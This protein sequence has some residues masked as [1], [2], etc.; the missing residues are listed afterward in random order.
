MTGHQPPE[1][2]TYHNRRVGD[3]DMHEGLMETEKSHAMARKEVLA[4]LICSCFC[5]VI[6]VFGALV[7][8]GAIGGSED[9]GLILMPGGG[10]VLFC[11]SVK[12]VWLKWGKKGTERNRMGS[13]TTSGE[14]FPEFIRRLHRFNSHIQQSQLQSFK[15]HHLTLNVLVWPLATSPFDPPPSYV[16]AQLIVHGPLNP[17]SLSPSVQLGAGIPSSGPAASRTQFDLPPSY[18]EAVRGAKDDEPPHSG[19]SS[20]ERCWNGDIHPLLGIRIPA[21]GTRIC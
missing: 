9:L 19:G 6:V 3:K 1:C 5:V 14:L 12:L 8:A 20:K 4:A 11:V 7:R 13:T 10:F 16:E 15:S 21:D 17:L 2:G 18:E